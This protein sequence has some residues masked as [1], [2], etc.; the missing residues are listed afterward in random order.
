MSTFFQ[1]F[2]L[3]TRELS[4]LIWA[5]IFLWWAL[6]NKDVRQSFRSLFV[7]FSNFKVQII[8]WSH[9]LWIAFCCCLLYSLGLWKDS[10]LKDIL[11]WTIVSGFASINSAITKHEINLLKEIK[12]GFSISAVYGFFIAFYSFDLWVELIIVPL[13]GFLLLIHAMAG[14]RQ[15]WEITKKAFDWIL[16]FAGFIYLGF[17]G[18]YFYRHISVKEFCDQMEVVILIFIL[19]GLLFPLL[20]FW[21]MLAMYEN[22][23]GLFKANWFK[24]KQDVAKYAKKRIYRYCHFNYRHLKSL[25]K[26][27]E[28][29]GQLFNSYSKEDIDHA[30][31]TVTRSHI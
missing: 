17:Y 31:E 13:F 25:C 3:S 16:A 27:P 22:L 9:F 26:N 12:N 6:K 15:E 10:F 5:S 29:R 20:Y 1:S 23:I 8:F 30:F 24:D 4:T 14:T 7:A 21:A 18:W 28:F 2:Q 19:T 11:L